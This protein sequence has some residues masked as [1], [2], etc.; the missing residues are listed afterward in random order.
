M[1]EQKKLTSA[2]KTQ[3]R[4][5]LSAPSPA[6]AH[7]LQMLRRIAL[8][9]TCPDRMYEHVRA[10]GAGIP[11][12]PSALRCSNARLASSMSFVPTSVQEQPESRAQ[13]PA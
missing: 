6:A 8:G 10:I 5:Q 9:K 3:H 7:S 1:F 11:G 12:N 13:R 4:A 2:G